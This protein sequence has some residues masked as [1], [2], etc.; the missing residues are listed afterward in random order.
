MGTPGIG[1]FEAALPPSGSRPTDEG[2]TYAL[3]EPLGKASAQQ[4]EYEEIEE[5]DEFESEET[6]GV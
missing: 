5:E 3:E 4:P 1:G 2:S 6:G